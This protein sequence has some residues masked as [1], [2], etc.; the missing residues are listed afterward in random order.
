VRNRSV[1]IIPIS[2]IAGAAL[3]LPTTTTVAATT[4]GPNRTAAPHGAAVAAAAVS[5]VDNSAA[6]GPVLSRRVDAR[7]AGTVT[8]PT[9]QHL[10]LSGKAGSETVL[11][12]HTGTAQSDATGPGRALVLR[13][14]AGHTYV[15]PAVAE[16]YL[17]R[18][19][20]PRLF[21]VTA[22]DAARSSDGRIPL[23][24]GYTGATPSIPG[25]RVTG[26][27][28]GTARGYLTPTSAVDFGRALTAAWKADERAGAPRRT[29]LFPGVTMI[30]PEATGPG[31]VQPHF[32]MLTLVIKT[33]DAEGDPQPDSFIGVMNVDDGRKY[34]AYVIAQNGEARISVPAGTYALI[35]DD[36]V[37]DEDSGSARLQITVVNQYVVS[38]ADQTVTID[39]RQATVVPSVAVP[40]PASLVDHLLEVDRVDALG[41]S[42]LG[43]GYSVGPETEVKVS[44]LS[45]A[46]VGKLYLTQNWTLAGPEPSSWTYSLGS[47]RERIPTDLVDSFAAKD[48]ATLDSTYYGDGSSVPG[49][50][51]RYPTFPEIGSGGGTYERIE[52]G[53]RRT[54]YVGAIG[55]KP[56]W[57]EAGLLNYDSWD[58]PGFIDGPDRPIKAGTALTAEWFRGPQ[59]AAIPVQSS[60]PYCFACRSGTSLSIGLAP[61]TDTDPT[62]IGSIFGAEDGIPVARFRFYRDG[63]LVSDQDDY[64]GGLF[65]VPAATATYRAVLDVDRRLS[66]PRQSTRTHTELT[67][68]SASGAGPA[69]PDDW[70]CD[71]GDG[72]GCRI[73]PVLQARAALPTDRQGR[74]PAGRS[75]VTVT[76]ARI[77]GAGPAPVTS[78]TLEV[79]PAGY[80]W[81]TLDLTPIGGGRYRGV[82]DNS[83]LEGTD[84]DLRVGGTDAGGSAVNQTILHAYTVAGS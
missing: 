23:R 27:S 67:F 30:A 2:L 18:F 35:G 76:L 1:R 12:D 71:A 56:D 61:F 4:A 26:A 42:L 78:A 10:R 21:D 73:L 29:S 81:T 50:F 53:L 47:L 84:V 79:R 66:A 19:L 17:G 80:P 5:S 16:R 3:A 7:R 43:A 14:I 41:E 36:L 46:K 13:R 57:T 64:L 9:G 11:V 63:V 37:Y 68:A 74:L 24:I 31:V 62:H 52:R 82:V 28:A 25:V 15:V 55:G 39:Q 40:K 6:A 22:L 54:E 48:L 60:Y 34:G 8:L 77:Q 44:P 45:R 58:D 38:K 33:L 49:G 83:D 69:A 75:T 59:P 72:T 20:D 51:V 32:P 70:Y 65:D